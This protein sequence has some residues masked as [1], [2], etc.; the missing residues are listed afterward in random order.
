MS[1]GFPNRPSRTA[2]G[3]IYENARPTRSPT[4]NAGA[5]AFNLSFFQAAGSGLMVPKAWFVGEI[6]AG[7][8]VA[9]AQRAES[10]NPNGE[11]TG[12][13][14]PHT[15]TYNSVGQYSFE[16]ALQVPDDDGN[17]TALQFD[18]GIA[19]ARAFPGGTTLALGSVVM[20]TT[21][22]GI[23]RFVSLNLPSTWAPVDVNFAVALY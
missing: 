8:D 17:L 18:W 9:L 2:F 15:L 4:K 11:T 20:T 1:G 22:A 13:F 19:V 16:Y 6:V 3:P 21:I 14:A 5:T 7:P 10:W 23:I 12:D